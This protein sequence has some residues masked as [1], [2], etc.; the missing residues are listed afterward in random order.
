MSER[1]KE[2]HSRCDVATLEG[3]NPSLCIFYTPPHH[4]LTTRLPIS[5]LQQHHI[6]LLLRFEILKYKKI[7]DAFSA[8]D[9]GYRPYYLRLALT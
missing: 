2:S 6:V 7:S 4:I 1:S 5:S 3:S 9:L 8:D